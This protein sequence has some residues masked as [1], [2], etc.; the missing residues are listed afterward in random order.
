MELDATRES[1]TM[2]L[3]HIFIIAYTLFLFIGTLHIAY[4]INLRKRIGENF[5]D[6]LSIM[7]NIFG[8]TVIATAVVVMYT[9]I[10]NM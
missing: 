2:T 1:K 7:G 4:Y 3:S 9:L 8:L 5:I 10:G 6:E